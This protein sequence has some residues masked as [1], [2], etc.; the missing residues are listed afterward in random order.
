MKQAD[1]KK[2]STEDIKG[3]LVELKAEY[4]KLKLVHKINPIESP[5]QIRDLRRTIARL[6]TELTNKQ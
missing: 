1:I 6:E 4:G 2:L 5:I 3:K